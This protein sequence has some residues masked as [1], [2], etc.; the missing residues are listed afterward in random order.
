MLVL[1]ISKSGLEDD[2]KVEYAKLVR[3]QMSDA[4]MLLVRYNCRSHY[5]VKMQVYCNQYNLTKHLPITSLLEFKEYKKTI[6]EKQP[7]ESSKLLSGLDVMF[8]TLRKRATKMLYDSNMSCC[9]YKSSHR[10][11]IKLSYPCSDNQTFLL[12]LIYDKQVDRRGAGK[13][14]S[15]DENALDCFTAKQLLDMFKDFVNELFLTS[16]YEKY[17]KG[18][19]IQQVG[20]IKDTDKITNFKIKASNDKRLALSYI[21]TNRRDNPVGD[22]ED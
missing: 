22:L 3:G 7:Q 6:V 8:I 15:P 5:G 9:E 17:N 14:V 21:Q 2:D 12:E 19:E 11:T 4:E 16:N 13:R 10:Y 18:V 1:L 20:T